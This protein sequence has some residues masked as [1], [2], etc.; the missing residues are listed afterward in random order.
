MDRAL[1]DTFEEPQTLCSVNAPD[2]WMFLSKSP[3]PPTPAPALGGGEPILVIVRASLSQNRF[4]DFAVN[5]R[6]AAVDA[7]VAEGQLLVVDA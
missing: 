7:I 3:S 2:N 6:E 1:V 5:I 4:D